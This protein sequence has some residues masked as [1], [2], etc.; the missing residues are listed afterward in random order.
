[1]ERCVVNNIKEQLSGL[2]SARQHGFQSGKSNRVVCWL[3]IVFQRDQMQG[4]NH[5]KETTFNLRKLPDYR[6]RH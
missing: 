5:Y 6:L 1:M 2:I 4:P 3:R